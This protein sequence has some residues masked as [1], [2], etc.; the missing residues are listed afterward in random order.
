MVHHRI[1]LTDEHMKFTWS[2]S[3]FPFIALRHIILLPLAQFYHVVNPNPSPRFSTS[4]K[5]LSSFLDLFGSFLVLTN[6]LNEAFRFIFSSQFPHSA[7]LSFHYFYPSFPPYIINLLCSGWVWIPSYSSTQMPSMHVDIVIRLYFAILSDTCLP[8]LL[9][10][11]T[12]H[13]P[14]PYHLKH[15]YGS[16]L[17]S[18]IPNVKIIR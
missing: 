14:F 9:C 16:S 13:N 12:T 3:G 4:F 7:R 10:R 6:P 11:Q 5:M 18:P 2:L 17:T 8:T 15:R 1:Q